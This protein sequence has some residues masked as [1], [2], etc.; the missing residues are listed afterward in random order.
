MLYNTTK[1]YRNVAYRLE[2]HR[3]GVKY[4]DLYCNNATIS[5]VADGEIK[6]SLSASILLDNRINF[7]SDTIC[8]YM[9]IDGVCYP[10][11]EYIAS[12]VSERYENGTST[13]EIEAY[14]KGLVLQQTALED[15]IYIPIGTKYTDYVGSLLTGAG[16][17]KAI[18]SDS[19][20]MMQTDRED[21]EIGTNYLEIINALLSEINYKNIWFDAE[22]NARVEKYQR[23]TDSN[24]DHRYSSGEMSL[25]QGPCSMSSDTYQAYNVFI[26][27]IS[28][29]D[30]QEPLKAVSVNDD[31]NSPL[32]IIR[33][34][35]RIA[36]PVIKLNNIASQSELQEYVD[37]Q[38]FASMVSTETIEF[39]TA[40]LPGHGV[41]DVI[42]IDH[43]KLKG[44]YLETEW[45]MP[46]SYDGVM[47]H[48][49]RRLE[50]L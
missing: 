43:E 26:A 1:G 33:R 45:S 11:G 30:Y 31:P 4:A 15:R 36:A 32:S 21:W 8:P 13:L 2:A 29:A 12:T 18:I 50:Y 20:Q 47:T 46:L 25:I 14:D 22:G 42:A 3:N 37:N 6:T 44:I 16:I 19:P 27:L 39:T 48:K 5:M 23:P 10:L 28:S 41:G 7:L 24:I 17:S 9:E 38:R 40:N 34:G 49:A 35:R